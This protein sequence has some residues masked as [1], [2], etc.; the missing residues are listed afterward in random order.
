MRSTKLLLILTFVSEGSAGL[1]LLLIPSLMSLQLLGD[2][3][4]TTGA[5][6]LS[7]V[8]GAALVAIALACWFAR[9]DHASV[10][11]R[12]LIIGA[13]AYNA[14]VAVVLIHAGLTLERTGMALWPG[15]VVHSAF[16]VWCLTCL[17]PAK[18]AL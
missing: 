14:V 8:L 13:L 17:R 11:Q 3:E 5:I 4:P 2:A 16:A 12:A 6:V 15:V 7:R 9:S 10:A 1:V 18:S